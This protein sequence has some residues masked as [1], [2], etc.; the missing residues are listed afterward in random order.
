MGGPLTESRFWACSRLTGNCGEIMPA[1]RS[2][3]RKAAA[4]TVD[5]ARK[6][7][8]FSLSFQNVTVCPCVY[9][10]TPNAE[11]MPLRNVRGSTCSKRPLICPLRAGLHT[12]P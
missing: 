12:E 7:S 5:G 11:R 10:R 9:Q 6:A 3:S 1:L 2:M 8:V 4:E